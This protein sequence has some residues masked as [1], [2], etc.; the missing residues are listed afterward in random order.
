MWLVFNKRRMFCS[1][2]G[3]LNVSNAG[4]KSLS[5]LLLLSWLIKLS[6][7]SFSLATWTR[8][9][10]AAVL[11]VRLCDAR[12]H[13]AFWQSEDRGE[14]WHA[15]QREESEGLLIIKLSLIAVVVLYEKSHYKDQMN[16]RAAVAFQKNYQ[17]AGL[18]HPSCFCKHTAD[19]SFNQRL[20]GN[21]QCPAVP[22]HYW[23]L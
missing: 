15:D 23:A 14:F 21:L 20:V 10:F 2:P 6:Q 3:L 18:Y 17:W 8:V 19:P 11:R 5:L 1:L 7:G 9:W 4:A 13:V 16:H 12:C 22:A